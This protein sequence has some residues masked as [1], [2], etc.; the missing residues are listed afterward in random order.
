MGTSLDSRRK[1]TA[2]AAL[3][4]LSVSTDSLFIRLADIDGFDVT[5]WIGVFSVAVL[6][7]ILTLRERRAPFRLIVKGG[8]PLWLAGA[9]QAG[10]TCLF[11]LAVTQ[12]SLIHI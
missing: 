6:G 1:G 10:S 2:L 4:M 11:V 7:A 3:G 8:W 12:L 5:F 9:L